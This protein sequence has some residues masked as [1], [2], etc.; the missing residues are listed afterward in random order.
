MFLKKLPKLP[1]GTKNSVKKL[2]VFLTVFAAI[3]AVGQA[4]GMEKNEES[5]KE[6][7]FQIKY[8]MLYLCNNV[9]SNKKHKKVVGSNEIMVVNNT[10]IYLYN[11]EEGVEET[12]IG[13]YKTDENK[14]TFEKY[15]ENFNDQ[16]SNLPENLFMQLYY[17]EKF[18]TEKNHVTVSVK[19]IDDKNQFELYLI[20]ANNVNSVIAAAPL[21]KSGLVVYYVQ[22]KEAKK[23]ILIGT[24]DLDNETITIK[25]G[26]FSSVTIN[27]IKEQLVKLDNNDFLE[28]A[29]QHPGIEALIQQYPIT[30]SIEKIKNEKQQ[31]KVYFTANAGL[32]N[33]IYTLKLD[34]GK[35][36]TMVPKKD[37]DEF[38]GTVKDYSFEPDG[39]IE[40]IKDPKIQKQLLNLKDVDFIRLCEVSASIEKNELT[41]LAEKINQNNFCLYLSIYSGNND[42]CEIT[43]K[44]G[45]TAHIIPSDYKEPSGLR[46]VKMGTFNLN[47]ETISS[48]DQKVKNNFFGLQDEDVKEICRIESFLQ[49]KYPLAL[50]F[51][52][53]N[54]PNER[55]YLYIVADKNAQENAIGKITLKNGTEAYVMPPKNNYESSLPKAC[56]WFL[57]CNL[58][59]ERYTRR[60]I[61]E[62]FDTYFLEKPEYKH[63]TEYN[64][65]DYK[66]LLKQ[67]QTAV[68]LKEEKVLETEEDNPTVNNIV[69]SEEEKKKQLEQ[70]M[71]KQKEAKNPKIE[72]EEKLRIE[73]EENLP[74]RNWY[75][76]IVSFAI[77]LLQ[78]GLFGNSWPAT[79]ATGGAAT[80]LVHNA[81]VNK[82]TKPYSIQPYLWGIVGYN[83][84][85]NFVPLVKNA[86]KHLWTAGQ[87]KEA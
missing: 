52:E 30:F 80:I 16:L 57:H 2:L 18:L 60:R 76:A 50:F 78:E 5:K 19:R 73:Q 27:E 42:V 31:F 35:M 3:T 53:N 82:T 49:E 46:L 67:I 21:S 68:K 40:Q 8:D 74:Q 38:I 56:V 43:L 61:M 75:S 24:F 48:E 44:N 6:L 51:K 47:N 70:N 22:P 63:L 71:G 85:R 65:T 28:L 26:K 79:L 33:E 87:L 39:N 86:Q 64:D 32:K 58:K 45:K 23:G 84:G 4:W 29:K 20:E 10:T 1:M 69:K 12:L 59:D 11:P 66:Q 34:N 62:K 14:K 72:E 36:A 55:S 13:F 37:A 7:F 81:V 15:T 41:V 83:L 9:K 25:D 77:G 17:Q 54:G